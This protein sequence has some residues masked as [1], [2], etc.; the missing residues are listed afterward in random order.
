MSE[1]LPAVQ[2]L[3]S[4]RAARDCFSSLQA[5][6]SQRQLV[7]REPPA[8]PTTCCGR[9]CNGCV[10]EGFFAAAMYWQECALQALQ[11]QPKPPSQNAPEANTNNQR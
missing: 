5:L 4:L 8:A 2:N 11:T 3:S 10:W 6:A 9:G 7:L 1:P